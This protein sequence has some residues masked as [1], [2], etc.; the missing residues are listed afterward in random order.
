MENRECRVCSSVDPI[1]L[2]NVPHR[3]AF[4]L[5]CTACVLRHHG[6]SFC[7][8]C[9]DV[10]EDTS[11]NGGATAQSR[12]MC[13][14]CPATAHLACFSSTRSSSTFRY[15][16]PQCSNPSFSFFDYRPGACASDGSSAVGFTKDLGRQLLCA[17]KI[18]SVSVHKAA[19]VARADAERK[20]R[21]ALLARRRAKEA[22]E[23]VA[24]L[25]A[26]EQIQN[27]SDVDDE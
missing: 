3:G 17:A 6:G 15:L 25:V 5:L 26:N 21:E 14:H 19:A 1:I 11:N 13:H 4:A 10:Y 22:I 24:Y 9:F 23:R 7:P 27:E 16:C 12:V 2:H 20:V 8:I 18:V